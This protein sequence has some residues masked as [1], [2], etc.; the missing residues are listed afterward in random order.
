MSMIIIQFIVFWILITLLLLHTNTVIIVI[1]TGFLYALGIDAALVLGILSWAYIM[2]KIEER[3]EK[4]FRNMDT[5]GYW[6][7]KKFDITI[8]KKTKVIKKIKLA[9]KRNENKLGKII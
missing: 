3:R 2:D 4:Q 1:A 6:K 7:N 5:D 8:D 9:S